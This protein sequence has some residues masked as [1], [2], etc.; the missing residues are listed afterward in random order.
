MNNIHTIEL[1]TPSQ[2]DNQASI[3][4]NTILVCMVGRYCAVFSTH[5][6]ALLP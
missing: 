1:L 5:R 2:D 6:G 3:S 4:E